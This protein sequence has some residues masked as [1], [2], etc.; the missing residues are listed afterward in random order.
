MMVRELACTLLLLKVSP[1]HRLF[2][3]FLVAKPDGKTSSLKDMLET[4]LAQESY[5]FSS[6]ELA[7]FEKYKSMSCEFLRLC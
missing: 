3:F 7:T 2:L 6:M 4:V 5:L 1:N